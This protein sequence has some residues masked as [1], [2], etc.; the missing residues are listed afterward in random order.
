M[1]MKFDHLNFP[2][3]IHYISKMPNLLGATWDSLDSL[4]IPW[5]SLKQLETTEIEKNAQAFSSGLKPPQAVSSELKLLYYFNLRFMGFY[6][7]RMWTN[8]DMVQNLVVHIM[9]TVFS[10]VHAWRHQC[11]LYSFLVLKL[12]HLIGNFSICLT[13]SRCT[14]LLHNLF[15]KSLH[16]CCTEWLSCMQYRS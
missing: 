3:I 2:W 9:V 1:N 15:H 4:D 12:H 16:N 6:V 11:F 13:A 7:L 5:C 8:C 14:F 10:S